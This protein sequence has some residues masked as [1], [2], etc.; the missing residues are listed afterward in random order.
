MIL[1][2][3]GDRGRIAPRLPP[4]VWGKACRYGS[5]PLFVPWHY[6]YE[7]NVTESV[8]YAKQVNQRGTNS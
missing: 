8:T 7:H 6:I 3:R 4:V 1:G 2:L 5:A